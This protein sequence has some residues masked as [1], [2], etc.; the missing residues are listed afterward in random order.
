MTPSEIAELAK[1]AGQL[2]ELVETLQAYKLKKAE[3]LGLLS[4]LN[5]ANQDPEYVSMARAD[6]MELRGE[7]AELE[8]D[9][10]DSFIPVDEADDASAILEL[11]PGTGGLEAGLFAMDMFK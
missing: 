8:D 3:E 10:L 7:L 4:I 1:E 9:L 2:R 5:D 6:W 11:R